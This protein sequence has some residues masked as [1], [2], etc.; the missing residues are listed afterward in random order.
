MALPSL[1]G[2][3]ASKVAGLYE[4]A[5]TA[6]SVLD[7]LAHDIDEL[8]L[9][10]Q[11]EDGLGVEFCRVLPS[12][13]REYHSVKRQAPSSS[14]AW[15]PRQLTRSTRSS[16]RSVLGDLFGHLGRSKEARGVFVSQD[17]ARDMREL[18]ER[19]RSAASLE[20]FRGQ[21]SSGL[22]KV[23]DGC[24]TPLAQHEADA[25]QKLRRTEFT[26][27]GHDEL[28]HFVEQR[29]PALVQRADGRA[30]DPFE[31]RLLLTDFAWHRLGQTITA[32]DVVSELKKHGYSEQPLG[33]S[34]QVRGSIK[35][36][37]EAY[38]HRI[39]KTLINGA[40]IP[41]S[42][43]A[44]IVQALTTGEQSLLLAGSAGEGKT[45]LMAQVLKK[46]SDTNVPHLVL[47]M[48]ELEGIVSSADLG[49]R[50]GFPA[51]PVIVLGKMSA[52]GRA[53]LCIDQLDA[54]SFVSG[55]NVQGR[56]VLEELVVQAT[57]YPELRILLACRAFDL[58]R[59]ASLS[60]LVSVESPAARRI[61][62]ERL[63][64]EDV[65]AALAAAGFTESALTESQLELLRTPL[66]LYL[67]LGGGTSRDGFG[68]RRDLFDRY[69]DDKRRRVDEFTEVGAFVG[70][71]DRLSNCLS[72]C[73]Q[74]QAPLRAFV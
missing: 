40:H 51:S 59:D 5:W 28:V 56:E 30:A 49:Q 42:Q 22:Q 13:V 46:F 62:I 50:M 58:D 25:Y 4:A 8:R 2:G 39:Q 18:A 65:Y 23:F 12:G 1:P 35:D 41:R 32:V 29:I 19:S 34:V 73:R 43:A 45:C 68:S 64:V 55:R 71:V 60:A 74:L 37:N 27:I 67:F 38:I 17:S 14:S 57:R 11:G 36:R 6:S 52:G 53:V 47:S 24:V 16:A 10:S 63:T 70:T 9:E 21:L 26:A 61:N 20:E 72:T 54:L 7:L 33:M 69:W 44:A 3:T 15:T 48:E 66:H 31:V